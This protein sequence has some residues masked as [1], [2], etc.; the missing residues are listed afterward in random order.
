[1]LLTAT[2]TSPANSEPAEGLLCARC[3]YDLRGLPSTC[4]PECGL[5]FDPSEVPPVDVPWLRR[6]QI[7]TFR[8]YFTTVWRVLLHPVQFGEQVWRIGDVRPPEAEAFARFTIAV[9]TLCTTI[10]TC[11][12]IAQAMTEPSRSTW[13]TLFVA[14]LITASAAFVFFFIATL[15]LQI[16]PA[17]GTR[18]H[19]LRFARMQN[20][21]CAGLGLIV[22]LPVMLLFVAVAEITGISTPGAPVMLA[23]SGLLAV[24]GW[25]AG[26]MM[27][28]AFGGR[29]GAALTIRYLVVTMILWILALIMAATTFGLLMIVVQ[30]MPIW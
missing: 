30:S 13:A 27:F 1:V 10:V 15:R 29:L 28:H 24:I 25:L 3:G 22:V 26:A 20:Y 9:A 12:P 18:Q 23:A 21:A 4:C 8:A 19:R 17:R 6:R 7:G 16:N 14:S 11:G 2:F 5:P